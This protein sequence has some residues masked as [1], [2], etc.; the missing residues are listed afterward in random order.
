LPGHPEGAQQPKDLILESRSFASLRMTSVSISLLA[1]AALAA[2]DGAHRS[3]GERLARAYCSACHA[4]PEPQLLAKETWRTGVLPQMAP[5]VGASSR[6]LSEALRNPHLVVLTDPVPQ[7]DW[8]KI[9]GYYLQSAPDTLPPQSLPAEPRIDSSL[10]RTGSLAPRF[11]SSGIITLLHSDSARERVFVGEAG[12]NQLRVF[13]WNRRSVARHTLGSPATD[14]IVERYSILVLESGI[15]SPNDE[16]RGA[17]VRYDF[18]G[19]GRIRFSATVIDSLF[20]PVFVEQF[21]FDGDGQQEFVV[22]EY[23]HNRG[24]L[25]LYA[26]DGLRHTRQV[27]DPNPGAIRVEIRD[28]TGDGAPDIVALFAQG[29]ERLALFE[30][31]GRG[32]FA[33]RPRVLARFPPV[34]GSM[35]FSMHDFN[36]DGSIDILYVNGDNFDFSRVRKPYHGVRIL[37][38]DG[39]NGFQERFFFPMYGAARAEVADFDRDGDLDILAT[40]NFADAQHPERGIVFLE[41]TAP[42]EFRPF[43]FPVASGTQWNLT[44]PADLNRDGWPDVIIA[45]M[46]LES[47]ATLQGRPGQP[48]GEPKQTLLLF[49][50]IM[51]AHSD[52]I[53]R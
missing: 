39:A 46:D 31:D 51:G 15:L 19:A 6:S 14:L 42:Y 24:R 36:G 53:R 4:F 13:D 2:C 47:I 40:S 29:D 45:A 34:Y 17:L 23:G 43:A 3:E 37:E 5:R 9:V 52:S 38:N 32:R 8:G 28:M 35:F 1:C 27:L 12:S 48:P 10:F 44:A 20:R 25:A 30:N 26:F 11:A 49:E 16:P 18:A 50:N 22:C 7:Q 41:S 33:R 21:D